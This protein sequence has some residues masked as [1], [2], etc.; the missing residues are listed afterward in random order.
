MRLVDTHT[1]LDFP[2]FD[3][4]RSEVLGQ[5][6]RAGVERMVVLG[7]YQDNWQRVWELVKS[8][9]QL[10]AA[11]GLHPVYLEQH[12]PEHL[13]ALGDWLSRLR[14]DRQLCAVGEFGLDYYVAELDRERQ[15]AL[16]EAQLQ[17]AVDFDLPALLH[18]RRSHADVIAR[19][20][21]FKLARG[22]IVHAFAGSYEEAR[23]YRR[24]G[25]RL[26]LGGAATWP[27]ALRLRKVLPRLGL[28]GVVL[29]TDSPDMAPA[30]YAG[31]RNSPVHLPQIAVA[32]AE[33]MGVAPQVLAEASTRN[34]CEL[35]GW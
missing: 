14:G 2:D 12:R 23:E 32:L 10:Y 13:L 8:D 34:A 4:D 18:V 30:M 3:A 5:A 31:V 20:K 29:E 27:Q 24:L 16:F 9:P 7:V 17:L 25:F 22:G 21:R 35:F 1:H 11:F 26:G 33:V 28:D 15:Q 19:L 6:R